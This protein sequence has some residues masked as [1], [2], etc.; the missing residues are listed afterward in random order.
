MYN[1]YIDMKINLYLT[2]ICM[3]SIAMFQKEA[4]VTY[5][6]LDSCCVVG[7]LYGTL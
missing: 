6:V 7:D 4:E 3:W 2:G 5:L 1:I